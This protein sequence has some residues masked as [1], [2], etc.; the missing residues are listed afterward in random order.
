LPRRSELTARSVPSGDTSTNSMNA[1]SEVNCFASAQV[2]GRSE[3]IGTR[4]TLLT[5]P[6][7]EYAN[8]APSGENAAER[9][10]SPWVTASGSPMGVPSCATA[11]CQRSMLPPRFE[12]KNT[13][14]PSRDQVGLHT[15]VRPS[16]S[17]TASPPEAAIVQRRV[18]SVAPSPPSTYANRRPSGA[19]SKSQQTFP[20]C[21]GSTTRVASNDSRDRTI[22][23]FSPA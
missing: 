23:T 19:T 8:L 10:P 11:C 9:M 22:T 4:Q 13:L 12:T 18:T 6:P 2:A 16:V 15:L 1:R 17:G 5:V 20:S 14:L 3:R 21:R 7:R